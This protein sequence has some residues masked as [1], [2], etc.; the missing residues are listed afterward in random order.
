MSSKK[1][2]APA[3]GIFLRSS[4]LEIDLGNGASL[5]AQPHAF[6]FPATMSD[7]PPAFAEKEGILT[8]H[9]DFVA[10]NIVPIGL[11]VRHLFLRVGRIGL[12]RP[13]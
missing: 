10:S 13:H 5:A 2:K 6:G 8:V 1:Q 4:N 7:F 9:M 3:C 12:T 11:S